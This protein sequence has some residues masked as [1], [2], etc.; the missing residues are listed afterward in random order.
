M[1]FKPHHLMWASDTRPD[2]F[3]MASSSS[4]DWYQRPCRATLT[5]G[6]C[7]NGWAW[8]Q[9]IIR[10]MVITLI[11]ITMSM[12][13]DLWAVSFSLASPTYHYHSSARR[14]SAH[15]NQVLL[16]RA[17][18]NVQNLNARI[19]QRRWNTEKI[20]KSDFFQGILWKFRSCEMCQ[21]SRKKKAS[22]SDARMFLYQAKQHQAWWSCLFMYSVH[23]Y[24]WHITRSH[25]KCEPCTVATIW[26]EQVAG[27]C[28][29]VKR[30]PQS[31]TL[32]IRC[33]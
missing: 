22:C 15:S 8:C 3:R 25:A 13:I 23:G 5:N 18:D 4:G 26:V 31:W 27:V 32:S 11:M 21:M 1:S 19:R 2:K 24:R 28:V 30:H 9:L 20:N 12:M 16:P 17:H 33:T 6:Y 10:L 7:S 14:S 29:S